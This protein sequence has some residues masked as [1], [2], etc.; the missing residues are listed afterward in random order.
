MNLFQRLFGSKNHVA[1]SSTT[2][3]RRT[4]LGVETLEA[5][6]LMRGTPIQ[7]LE[8]VVPPHTPVLKATGQSVVM[9]LTNQEI[10]GQM[11]AQ[12]NSYDQQAANYIN[13]TYCPLG[14]DYTGAAFATLFN[15]PKVK[16]DATINPN[17]SVAVEM[18]IPISGSF[19]YDVRGP[20]GTD[21][22][23]LKWSLS[24][25]A[26]I[27]FTL[28]GPNQGSVANV[29]AT[30][31]VI[32]VTVSGTDDISQAFVAVAGALGEIPASIALPSSAFASP[33]DAYFAAL[34]SDGYQNIGVRMDASDGMLEYF[35][36]TFVG[37][38]P[39]FPFVGEAGHSTELA[40]VV[41]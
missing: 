24:A 2:G 19:K 40:H 21:A 20:W 29:A 1:R 14:G 17:G 9:K 16:V 3:S 41:A 5:R 27:K 4:T 8:V 35:P 23:D 15:S 28:P 34:H 13:H 33:L 37:P 32:D 22:H 18:L 38:L 31:S 10:L 6:T 11:Q 39:G 12:F 25:D 30:V 7:G 26:D 36:D